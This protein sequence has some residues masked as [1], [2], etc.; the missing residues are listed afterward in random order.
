M[1]PKCSLIKPGLIAVIKPL[2]H[3]ESFG[4]SDFQVGKD[5]TPA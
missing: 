3:M 4:K 2:G 1:I 5:K